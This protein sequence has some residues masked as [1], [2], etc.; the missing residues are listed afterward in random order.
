MNRLSALLILA[1]PLCL[2]ACASSGDYPA[3][4][5]REVE[6][7]AGPAAP[8]SGVAQAPPASADLQARVDR[9]VGQARSGHAD[10]AA[11]RE[12]AGRSVAAAGG[13]ARASDG[14]VTA[15]VALASLEAA[16]SGAVTALA[17][18]DRL[19]A[20]E[21]IAVPHAVSPSASLLGAARGQV[22]AWIDEENDV[23]ASLTRRLGS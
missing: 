8:S 18:I 23:I 7:E 5:R 11:R 3:L 12:A 13:A 19:Y 16:R 4:G 1:L 20:D 17:D 10:F 14:W 22:K 9:L 2:E 15:Q 21:R 6:R